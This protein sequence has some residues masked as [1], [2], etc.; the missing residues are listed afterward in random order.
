[1]ISDTIRVFGPMR[2]ELIGQLR[3]KTETILGE[4][5]Y[6]YEDAGTFVLSENTLL[7]IAGLIKSANAARRRQNQK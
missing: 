1:M 3:Y 5:G 2:G 6:H 4:P 7:Y